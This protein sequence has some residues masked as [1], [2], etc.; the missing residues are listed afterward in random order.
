ML[1][2]RPSIPGNPEALR[3]REKTNNPD[4]F[5]KHPDYFTDSRVF[6]ELKDQAV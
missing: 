2:R 4:A 6:V 5:L 1:S 3:K